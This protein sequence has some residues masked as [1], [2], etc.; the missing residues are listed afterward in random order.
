MTAVL[1]NYRTPRFD[2]LVIEATSNANFSQFS[3]RSD[4]NKRANISAWWPPEKKLF[5][6]DQIQPF[7]TMHVLINALV[8]VTL[9]LNVQTQISTPCINTELY[10]QVDCSVL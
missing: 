4:I 10:E 2:G 1:E 5:E 7:R 9:C 8:S 6:D 3:N